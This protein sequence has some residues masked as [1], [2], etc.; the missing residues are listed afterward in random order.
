MDQAECNGYFTSLFVQIGCVFPAEQVID[1]RVYGLAA[2]CTC[3][4]L[5]L[6]ALN[7]FDY[8]KKDQENQYL[9]WDV[10]TITAGDYTVEFDIPPE[11]FERWADRGYMKFVGKQHRERRKY[12]I[13]KVDAFRDWITDEMERRLDLLPDLGYEEEP[14]E[15]VKIAMTSFAF[16]NA[17]TI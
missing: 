7:Y 8:I 12:Y 13:A 10:K 15:H 17:E 1:R 14:V 11:F 9:E 4:A 6:Y 16:R 3:V 5:A 2:G